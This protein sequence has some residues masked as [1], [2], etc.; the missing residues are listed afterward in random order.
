VE[1]FIVKE[2][3]RIASN[4]RSQKSLDEYLK[5]NKVVGIEGVDTR[6]LTRHIRLEGSMKGVISTTVLEPER[7][8][9]KAKDSQSL[10]GK[11]LVEPVTCRETYTWAADKNSRPEYKVVVVDCGVKYNILR[12]LESFD[13]RVTVV[14]AS[15]PAE[16]I[17][18]ERPDGLMISNGPGDPEG[19]LYVVATVKQLIGKLPIFGICMGHHMLTMALGGKMRKLKFGHHGGNQ[20]VKDLKTGKIYISVQNH[21]FYCDLRTL[22][23][24]NIQITHLNLNDNTLEGIRHKKHPLFAVQFHPEAS[25]GPHD[26]DYLFGDFVEMMKKFKKK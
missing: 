15:T 16:A 14:P 17:L 10:V 11:D 6:A 19:I 22:D 20:P 21:N 5:E 3:S 26:T 23:I 4:W 12:K 18:A 9:Q 2:C 7:L 8:V 1:A 25:P 24:R 13:C